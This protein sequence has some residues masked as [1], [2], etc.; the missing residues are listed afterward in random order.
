VYRVTA[1]GAAEAQVRQAI[2]LSLTKYCS[3]T[4]SL[5]PDIT[6][7]YELDLQA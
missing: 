7:R 1:P 5:A 4:H 2:D 6:I 3:V